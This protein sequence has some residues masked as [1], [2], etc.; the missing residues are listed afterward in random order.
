MPSRVQGRRPAGA[1]GYERT[2]RRYEIIKDLDPRA[3]EAL[4]LD[5][6]LLARR[7]KVK[8][9]EFRVELEDGADNSLP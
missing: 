3:V 2:V 4:R 1:E 7:Y 6:R 8:L 5:I 9:K